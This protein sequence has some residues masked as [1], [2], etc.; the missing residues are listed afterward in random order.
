[1][2][3]LD[4]VDRGAS[5]HPLIA[6]LSPARS[7]S[8]SG[9]LVHARALDDACTLSQL[10]ARPSLTVPPF[11]GTDLGPMVPR[12]NS[13]NAQILTSRHDSSGRCRIDSYDGGAGSRG[14]QGADSQGTERWHWC[15]QEQRSVDSRAIIGQQVE[16]HRPGHDD[17]DEH[18]VAWLIAGLFEEAGDDH[19]LDVHEHDEWFGHVHEHRNDGKHEHDTHVRAQRDLHEDLEQPKSAGQSESHAADGDVDRGGERRVPQSGTVH[20]GIERVEEPEHR[21]RSA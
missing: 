16:Q 14:H 10:V 9:T 17:Q 8:T 11:V 18:H 4:R 12:R 7:E 1:M 20:R 2:G 21:L 15:T 3:R 13:I 19:C 6:V 5:R